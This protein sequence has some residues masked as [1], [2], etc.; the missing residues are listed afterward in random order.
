M[1][2][3]AALLGKAI[4]A[5]DRAYDDNKMF[6]KLDALKQ[7]YVI[8]VE[9]NRKLPPHNKWITASELCNRRKGK[10]KTKL[11]YK[12]REHDACNQQGNQIQG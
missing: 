4:F 11:R 1:E 2:R 10:I 6:L 7:D 9:S 8:R 12:G 3:G 5:L